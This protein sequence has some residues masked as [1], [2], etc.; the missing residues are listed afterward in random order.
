VLILNPRRLQIYQ[1]I[2]AVLASTGTP[3][4]SI[5]LSDASS[6]AQAMTDG[7]R[8]SCFAL[9]AKTRVVFDAIRDVDRDDWVRAINHAISALPAA[10]SAASSAEA[11]WDPKS[12]NADCDAALV[13]EARHN[14][15]NALVHWQR[16]CEANAPMAEWRLGNRC[17]WGWGV[18]RDEEKARALWARAAKSGH[19]GALGRCC[20]FG[21][22]GRTVDMAQTFQNMVECARRDFDVDAMA[23]VGTLFDHGTGVAQDAETAVSWYVRA[24]CRRHAAALFNLGVCS[25]TGLGMAKDLTASVLFYLR[26]GEQ[27]HAAGCY[28]YGVSFQT[29][30][31]VEKNER[32]AT[33]WIAKAHELGYTKGVL[34]HLGAGK[35]L[36]DASLEVNPLQAALAQIED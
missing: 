12:G 18:A 4:L 15:R 3:L 26:A 19:R 25:A 1:D 30:A 32:K 2:V 16:A 31:G 17:W 22:D 10:G 34:S 24:A 23:I 9:P 33:E 13:C 5:S 11:E 8:S 35:A 7:K 28:N 20:Q 6:G 14:Y 27:G 21:L 29:G 36:E